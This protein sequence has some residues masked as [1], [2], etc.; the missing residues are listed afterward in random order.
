MEAEY[1][2]CLYLFNE[3]KSLDQTTTLHPNWDDERGRL[4]LFAGHTFL[5]LDDKFRD[6]SPYVRDEIQDL[7]G[8]L[9]SILD[10][11]K[12]SM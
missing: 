3:L 7:L 2:D 11:C 10:I 9:R 4:Q 5:S 8:D 1:Y 12:L 6:A